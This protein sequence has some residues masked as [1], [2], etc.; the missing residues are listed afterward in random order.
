MPLQNKGH[1]FS[2]KY[3]YCASDILICT[4]ALVFVVGAL[5]EI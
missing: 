5:E 2:I 1:I 4:P 3:V